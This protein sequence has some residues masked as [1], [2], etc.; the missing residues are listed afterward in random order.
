MR[1]FLAATYTMLTGN[2]G[3]VSA[4]GTRL[5]ENEAPQ[6]PT[7]PYAAYVVVTN[8]SVM[9]GIQQVRLQVNVVDNQKNSERVLIA[10]DAVES[11]FDVAKRY[12]VSGGASAVVLRRGEKT[13]MEVLNDEGESLGW[14]GV[15]DFD[16]L[17]SK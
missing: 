4:I 12:G 16:I 15:I 2:A 17:Y 11:A 9:R 10:L 8:G 5:Y 3:V 14:S 7:F 1:N 13:D 6:S